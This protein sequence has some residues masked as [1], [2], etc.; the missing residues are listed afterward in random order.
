MYTLYGIDASYCSV[1]ISVFFHFYLLTGMLMLAVWWNLVKC[2]AWE[3]LY[4]NMGR[5]TTMHIHWLSHPPTTITMVHSSD[6]SMY[7]ID[8]IYGFHFHFGLKFFS[9]GTAYQWQYPN[10]HFGMYIAL[11][12]KPSGGFVG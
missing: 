3:G 5:L 7:C 6:S 4:L 2:L 10:L 12:K 9:I 1:Y 11:N 8:S